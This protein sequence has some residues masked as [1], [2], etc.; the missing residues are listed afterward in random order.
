MSLGETARLF[1]WLDFEGNRVSKFYILRPPQLSED[2]YY[3]Y[4]VDVVDS[5]A[6][7]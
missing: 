1:V 2:F 4:D 7:D 6:M 3:Q 5:L